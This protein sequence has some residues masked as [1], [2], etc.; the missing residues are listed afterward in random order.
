[1]RWVRLERHQPELERI[2]LEGR[3]IPVA[4]E[5]PVA[6]VTLSEETDSEAELAV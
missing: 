2:E 3:R 4:V 1:L 5:L 6:T